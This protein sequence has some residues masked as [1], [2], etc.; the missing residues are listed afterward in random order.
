M[1]AANAAN[2]TTAHAASRL[3]ARDHAVLARTLLRSAVVVFSVVPSDER[4]PALAAL[5]RFLATPGPAPFLAAMRVLRDVK[6]D[7]VLR[8]ARLSRAEQDFVRGLELVRREI[9]PEVADV[10]SALP[11]FEDRPPATAQQ[12]RGTTASANAATAAQSPAMRQASG[13]GQ[14]LR[15]LALLAAAHQE[16]ADRVAGSAARLRQHLERA[17]DA[18]TAPPDKPAQRRRASPAR[19]TRPATTTSSEK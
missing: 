6:Q 8:Q 19:S 13:A 9:C 10:L 12:T 1:N 17:K 4:A 14:R 15:A 5:D 11:I 16:L 2:S 7:S 3:P 18:G